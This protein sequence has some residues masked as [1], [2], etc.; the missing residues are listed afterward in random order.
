MPGCWEA[1]GGVLPVEQ[2]LVRP[3]DGGA[4]FRPQLLHEFPAQG[5]EDLERLGLAPGP[6]QGDHELAVQFL[7]QRVLRGQDAE[8]IEDL[9][10]VPEAEAGVEGPLADLEAQLIELVDAQRRRPLVAEPGQVGQR[11]AAPQSQCRRALLADRGPVARLMGE[12]RGTRPCLEHLDVQVPFGHEQLVAGRY[13]PQAV[14][15]GRE[16][17]RRSR[18]VWLA[19]EA[20]ALEGRCSP[21]MASMRVSLDTT[22]FGASSRAASSTRTLSPVTGRSATPSSTTSGPSSPNL[23]TTSPTSVNGRHPYGRGTGWGTW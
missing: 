2:F 7:A 8:F 16:R 19:K 3:A 20:P 15:A 22:R 11:R 6:V 17:M 1:G 23:S 14:V 13:G 5:V 18:V 21:H 12:A 4:G 10:V 9:A